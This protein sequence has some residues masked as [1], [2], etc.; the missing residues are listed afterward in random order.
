MNVDPEEA[1]DASGENPRVVAEIYA[2]V[3]EM[4]PGLPVEAQPAWRDTANR[5]V[6]P[7]EPGAWPT[8]I[9]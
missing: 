4:L 3:M 8:P 1:E 7:N 9:L 5:R 6:Y 2:K